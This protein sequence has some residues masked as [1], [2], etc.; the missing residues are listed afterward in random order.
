MP[1]LAFLLVIRTIRGLGFSGTM[2]ITRWVWVM[3][4]TV[5]AGMAPFASFSGGSGFRTVP[6]PGAL[7][8]SPAPAG[9]KGEIPSPEVASAGGGTHKKEGAGLGLSPP[10]NDCYRCRG[11]GPRRRIPAQGQ[12]GATLGRLLFIADQ[13]M[14]RLAFLLVIRTMRALGLS[15]T[16]DMTWWVWEVPIWISLT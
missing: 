1:R 9:A 6:R 3:P 16:R 5:P 15:G 7:W 8:G 2:D 11:L 14:P 13:A 12:N 10:F 4:F